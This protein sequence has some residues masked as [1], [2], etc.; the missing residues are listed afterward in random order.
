M[1]LCLFFPR[2]TVIVCAADAFTAFYGGLVVFSVLGFLA[3][4]AG[5]PIEEFATSGMVY[6]F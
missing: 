1:F 6:T 4:E 2:D 3:K 5:K